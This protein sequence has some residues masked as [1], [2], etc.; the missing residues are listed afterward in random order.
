MS[1]AAQAVQEFCDDHSISR[2]FLYELWAA[3]KGPRKMM[4]GRKILISAEAAAEWRK[5]LEVRCEA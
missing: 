3:G 1:K 2:A 4:V 5:S